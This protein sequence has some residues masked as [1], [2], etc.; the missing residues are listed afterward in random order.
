MQ[1]QT[2]HPRARVVID[3]SVYQIYPASFKDSNGD[4]IGDLKGILSQVDYIQKLPVDIVWLNTIFKSPQIDMGYDISDYYSIHE[5]IGTI[6]D[7][8]ALIQ[9]LHYRGMK[10]VLDLLVNTTSQTVGE[11]FVAYPPTIADNVKTPWFVNAASSP[12]SRYA[13]FYISKKPRYHENGQRH[14][15]NNWASYFGGSAWEYDEPPGRYYSHLFRKR[16]PD[17]NCENPRVREELY[18]IIAFWLDR[19]ADGYRMDVINFISKHPDFP[20][21]PYNKAASKWQNRSEYYLHGR[22]LHEYWHDIG[23]IMKEYDRFSVGEMP[24]VKDQNEILKR[25][26]FDREELNMIFTLELILISWVSVD[27][28]HVPGGKF[29]RAN[30]TLGDMNRICSKW[31]TFMY[32]ND[33]WNRLYLENH[34]Q[35]RSISRF[36]LS[37]PEHRVLS[38]K[39]LAT[40]LGFQSGTVFVYQGDELGMRN[41]PWDWTIEKYRDI[42]TLNHWKEIP[43]TQTS[44]TEADLEEY[45]LK[46]RDNRRTPMTWDTLPNAGFS[47]SDPWIPVH[48]DFHTLNAAMQCRDPESAYHYVSRVLSLRKE[49]KDII[50]IGSFAL[51]YLRHPEV[52]AY[53][54]RSEDPNDLVVCNFDPRPVQWT[55]PED[56]SDL[57]REGRVVCSNFSPSCDGL[58]AGHR[59]SVAAVQR[60]ISV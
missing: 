6:D 34:D 13:D 28:D 8:D 60:L 37:S 55:V 35:P 39:M 11:I 48:E 38:A 14:P 43:G 1:R 7:V 17:L 44:L 49:F 31:Q 51:V 54:R 32:E 46:A 58:R 27:I 33:G 10:L 2:D 26:G 29:T 59:L 41:V 12:S 52:S 25:V 15:P 45:A 56:V 22:R 5:T 4:G 9:G 40:F 19:G 16:Q 20:D 36:A 30:W 23:M 53:V 21:A 57:L 24:E 42:E 3:S 50:V 47:T 18:R